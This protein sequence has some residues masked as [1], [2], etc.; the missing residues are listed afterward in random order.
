[1]KNCRD[2]REE[3]GSGIQ[4]WVA[5]GE[6]KA[7]VAKFAVLDREIPAQAE[8]GALSIAG[9][10]LVPSRECFKHALGLNTQALLV[11]AQACTSRECFKHA[12]VVYTQTVP[13]QENQA[14]P[15]EKAF[16]FCKGFKHALVVNTQAFPSRE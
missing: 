12:F 7:A 13:C 6:L 1:M 9:Y 4:C 5:L 15:C 16:P 2:N 3:A 14:C 11:P 8:F 10:K